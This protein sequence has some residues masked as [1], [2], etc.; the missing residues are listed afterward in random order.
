MCPKWNSLY[1]SILSNVESKHC[2]F[3]EYPNHPHPS[4][5]AACSETLLK[6]VKI[7]DRSKLAPKKVYMYHSVI[8]K[9]KGFPSKCDQWCSRETENMMG[10]S[11]DANL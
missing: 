2:S 4:R 5:H 8:A 11:Y 10:D 7:G 1:K 6:S 3:V 9:Q